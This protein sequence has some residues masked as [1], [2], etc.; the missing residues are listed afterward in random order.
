[1]NTAYFLAFTSG[2]LGG[3]GHCIGMCGPI[4]ASYAI[5]SRGEARYVFSFLPHLLYNAGRITT[6]SCIG[7]MMGLTGSFINIAGKL[8]GF[9]N[10]VSI[11]AGLIMIIMGLSVFWRQSVTAALERHNSFIL[12]A[13]KVVL[14]GESSWRYYSLGI[15]LGFLPCGLSYSAFIAS[16]AAGGLP[17]GMFLSFCFGLGTTPSLLAFG[18]VITYLSTRMRDRI[19]RAGG[20]AIV[21]MGVYFLYRGIAANA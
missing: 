2:L 13:V 8:A 3:F 12:K 1:M 17:Q 6:Y 18:S 19:F 7:A 21:A 4:V 15:L 9:Q 11:A 10:A 14:E 16:A 5:H 20:I